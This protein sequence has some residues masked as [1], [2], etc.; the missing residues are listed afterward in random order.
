[1]ID[2]VEKEAED[3]SSL[4]SK[5]VKTLEAESKEQNG[6]CMVVMVAVKP[7]LM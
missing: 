1:M 3:A 5:S 7:R 2:E 4:S 6:C